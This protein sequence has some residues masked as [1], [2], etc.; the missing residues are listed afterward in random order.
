MKRITTLI[1]LFLAVSIS[2]QKHTFKKFYSSHKADA[3]VSLNIP[4]FLA[5]MFID[6]DDIDEEELLEKASNF[7]VMV[8]NKPSRGVANDFKKF[9]KRNKFKSL[10]RV[11]DGSDRAEIYFVEHKNYIREIVISAGS[12]G[13]ELVLLGLKTKLTKEELASIISSTEVELASK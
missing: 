1:V 6:N 7:K 9:I 4:G 5:K 11:K 13:D 10:V 8:F 3:E 2:A 12:K